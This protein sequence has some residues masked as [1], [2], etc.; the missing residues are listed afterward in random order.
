MVQQ[1]PTIVG[2]EPWWQSWMSLRQLASGKKIILWGR[3]EDWVPKTLDRLPQK[4]SYVVDRNE[5]Y[6][7]ETF[8]GMEVKLP[9]AIESENR[10]ESYIIITAGPYEGILSVLLDRG[11]EPGRHFC[12][13][14]EFKDY[15]LL[16]AMRN[17]EQTLIVSCSDYLDDTKAR[18]SPAGGGLYRYH[19]GPNEVERVA[20]GCFR[21]VQAYN[22]YYFAV[23]YV[24]MSIHIFDNEFKEVEKIPL[25]HPNYCGLAINKDR[26]VFV[27]INA[28][29][30]TI[31][32]FNCENSELIERYNFSEKYKDGV[33]SNHHLNDCCIAGDYLYVSCFSHS[34]S[35]KKGIHD[36]GISEF[37]LDSIGK[38]GETLVTGLWKPH[39]PEI[40][41]GNLCYLDSMRGRLH[42]D[43]QYIAGTFSGFVRGL[44]NDGRFYYVGQSEDM[45]M[46]RVFG[47]RESIM[48]NA[49]FYMFDADTKASRFYPMLDN[50]NIHDLL[51]PNQ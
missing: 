3:S 10:D 28:A 41:D 43:N 6:T 46:S 13:C 38:G 39:S 12:C 45:Y 33:T 20:K 24:E 9:T 49:G 1:N 18:F 42:T 34:G 5:G 29:Y 23:E 2:N 21:Q 22:E 7:G 27:L 19:I 30:D 25:D 11:Y 40:I 8:F 32:I 48:L 31:S 16:E 15:Q 37:R 36:G 44:T 14:P 17:Y 50:M 51:I 4:A 26:K 47:S 35:W